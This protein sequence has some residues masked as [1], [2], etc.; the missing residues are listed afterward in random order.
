M[1]E[2]VVKT[3]I[4]SLFLLRLS[5]KS[6]PLWIGSIPLIKPTS[7]VVCL[8]EV[9]EEPW[10]EHKGTLDR[11]QM[12]YASNTLL[13]NS[14]SSHSPLENSQPRW[15]VVGQPIHRC[16]RQTF[17]NHTLGT[18]YSVRIR[19]SSNET[20]ESSGTKKGPKYKEKKFARI[21]RVT[22]PPHHLLLSL[23]DQWILYKGKSKVHQRSNV[24]R[25]RTPIHRYD[26]ARKRESTFHQK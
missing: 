14:H 8:H 4:S 10:R 22:S 23:P 16:R 9:Y 15:N 20:Q 26:K 7:S 18:A 21:L 2:N 11:F 1:N 25:L 17:G 6:V 19:E 3:A 24:E 12:E 13:Q 5:F